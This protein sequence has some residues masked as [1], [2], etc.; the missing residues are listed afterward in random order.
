MED[1]NLTQIQVHLK[2]P[3]GTGNIVSCDMVVYS[4][5]YIILMTKEVIGD[6]LLT[7][8]KPY[9]LD[10]IDKII[11]SRIAEK[12]ELL[13]E[14]NEPSTNVIKSDNTENSGRDEV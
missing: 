6:K 4:G 5:D 3:S 1:K 7:I 13:T 10:E 14:S 9:K 2:L 12:R 8:E 11:N